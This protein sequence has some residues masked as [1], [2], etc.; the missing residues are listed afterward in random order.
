MIFHMS[1]VNPPK[2]IFCFHHPFV[3]TNEKHLYAALLST[4][5]N[6]SIRFFRTSAHQYLS[7]F[8][9]YLSIERRAAREVKLSCAS[10]QFACRWHGFSI[11]PCSRSH[12]DMVHSWE[13]CLFPNLGHLFAN[14]LCSLPKYNISICVGFWWVSPYRLSFF[15]SCDFAQ[16]SFVQTIVA[17]YILSLLL[18][19]PSDPES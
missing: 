18:T 2:I 4:S 11:F 7:F 3:L 17:A 5:K 12:I 19:S 9:F 1:D 14:L 15:C 16:T 10:I 6:H 8:K 13:V